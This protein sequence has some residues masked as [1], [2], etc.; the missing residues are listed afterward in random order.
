MQAYQY[1][2]TLPF[3]R[4]FCKAEWDKIVVDAKKFNDRVLKDLTILAK[5]EFDIDKRRAR[6]EQSIKTEIAEMKKPYAE[7]LAS[8][9]AQIKKIRDNEV[10]ITK[11]EKVAKARLAK[12]LEEKEDME[13]QLETEE[14]SLKEMDDANRYDVDETYLL[15]FLEDQQ[16]LQRKELPNYK[17]RKRSLNSCKQS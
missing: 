15:N 16:S 10:R 3:D 1:R 7:Q 14:S 8:V 11:N 17:M 5:Q 6:V 13:V 2:P 9:T 4:E 12:L